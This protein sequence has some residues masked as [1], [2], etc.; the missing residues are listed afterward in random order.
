LDTSTPDP[1]IPSGN[2]ESFA[3]IV[4]VLVQR[5]DA[6]D[7][8]D[9]DF[10]SPLERESLVSLFNFQDKSWAEMAEKFSLRSMKNW[11]CMNWLTDSM[12]NSTV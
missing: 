12:M 8:G 7:E 1:N 3:E 2:S 9:A 6:D 11:N 5:S 10:T 4:D